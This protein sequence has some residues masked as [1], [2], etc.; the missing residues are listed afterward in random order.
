M[1]I[2]S[3]SITNDPVVGVSEF[4]DNLVAGSDSAWAPNSYGHEIRAMGG[5]WSAGFDILPNRLGI[6]YLNEYLL[7]GLGRKVSAYTQESGALAFEGKIMRM[8]LHIH[9]VSVQVSLENMTNKTW[10]RY[11]TSEGGLIKRSTVQ[12]DSGSQTAYGI[13][14]VVNSGA[15]I[16]S[17]TIADQVASAYLKEYSTPTRTRISIEVGRNTDQDIS[18]SV[19]CHG[20]FRTLNWRTYNQTALQTLQTVDEQIQDVIDDVGQFINSSNLATNISLVS[21]VYDRDEL[22]GNIILD[23]SRL[24]DSS[25][26]RY[27][28]G[29]YK[30]RLLKYEQAATLTN[31]E[32]IRYTFRMR[33][34]KQVFN[35]AGTDRELSPAEVRPNNWMRITDIFPGQI[36]HDTDLSKDPQTT[37]VES[38][39]F[40]EPIGVSIPSNRAVQVDNLLAKSGF[41]GASQI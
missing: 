14:E 28:V 15:I 29:V 41:G 5:F 4:T 22:A 7:N 12:E 30:D 27:V 16:P 20:Y 38:V 11:L 1:S 19:F 33:D 36:I 9:G 10:V 18:L 6:E 24:A 34:N 23:L 31:E 37:F 40:R 2:G 39:I 17:S 13:K 32:D 8:R 21:R 26:N 3:I 35:R 25:N